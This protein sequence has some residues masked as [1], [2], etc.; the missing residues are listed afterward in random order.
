MSTAPSQRRSFAFTLIEMLTTMAALVIVLGLMVSLA[1]YVR[2]RSAEALTL[3]LLGKLETI[4]QQYKGE[5]YKELHTAL[6]EV[7]PLVP[8]GAI[9]SDEAL[10]KRAERNSAE[11]VRIFRQKTN[12]GVFRMLP[13]A[14]YDQVMLHDAW[15]TPVVYMHPG[16]RNIEIELQPR[17]YFMSAGPDRRFAATGDNLYSY[18]RSLRP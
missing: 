14:L 13:A 11:F 16:A 5:Q 7:P 18:E 1:K 8:P 6:A 15:G 3:E 9:P 10:R 4:M 12:P 17:A 2:S